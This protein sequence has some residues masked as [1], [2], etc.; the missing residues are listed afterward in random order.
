LLVAASLVVLLFG[1]GHRHPA[2][3]AAK[4]AE[5]RTFVAVLPQIGTVFVR[6]DCMHGRRFALGIRIGRTQTTEVLFRAGSFRRYRTLQPGD[7]T[8]WFRYRKN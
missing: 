2:A 8:S 3:A 6:Y 7:P 5:N 1:I 4:Q